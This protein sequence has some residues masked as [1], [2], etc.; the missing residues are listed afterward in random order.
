MLEEAVGVFATRPRDV[1][2]FIANHEDLMDRCDQIEAKSVEVDVS[3][4]IDGLPKEVQHQNEAVKALRR[5]Q[6]EVAVQEEDWREKLES[7]DVM[8]QDLQQKLQ[9]K[10]QEY[11]SLRELHSQR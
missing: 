11:A 7:T 1:Y 4:D 3:I 9:R 2:H 6:K 8:V 5:M 10:E